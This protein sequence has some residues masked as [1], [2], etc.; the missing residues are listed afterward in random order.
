MSSRGNA[1]PAPAMLARLCGFCLHA[2][3]TAWADVVRA[4]C[5][6]ARHWVLDR[7]HPLPS[8]LVLRLPK[9]G[10]EAAVLG[11][12]A[13]VI[14]LEQLTTRVDDSL[15]SPTLYVAHEDANCHLEGTCGTL[16]IARYLGRLQRLH[17]LDPVNALLVDVH[18][19]RLGAILGE[20]SSIDAASRY[21][22]LASEMSEYL[23]S[24]VSSEGGGLS[25]FERATVADVCWY[26]ALEWVLQQGDEGLAVVDETDAPVQEGA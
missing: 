16:A 14:G 17:P 23:K 3:S 18:L 21:R 24:H 20:A 25:D 6:R 7:A 9:A 19:E 5:H 12:L 8:T 2:L 15:T 22:T 4:L 1:H 11:T 13:D 10:I 26:A